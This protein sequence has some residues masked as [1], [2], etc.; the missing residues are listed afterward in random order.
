MRQALSRRLA[1]RFKILRHGHG[2]VKPLPIDRG[3]ISIPEGKGEVS[4]LFD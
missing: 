1:L 2:R 3:H 4:P